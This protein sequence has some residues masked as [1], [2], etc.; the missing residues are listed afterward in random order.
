MNDHKPSNFAGGRPA[1]DYLSCLAKKGNPKKVPPVRRPSGFL[2]QPQASGAAQLAL[3]GHTNR[4]PLRSS[5]IT[6][7]NL[8][9]L[10]ADRG[11]AQG[12]ENLKVL[13]ALCA[14]FCFVASVA[15]ATLAMARAEQRQD[16]S[17]QFLFPERMA[18][19]EFCGYVNS[20]FS[21]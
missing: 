3:T 2:D 11:G 8:R 17:L 20:R 16:L 21:R 10:A 9:L 5:D 14:Q 13:C 7:L 15:C 4:A 1:T 12:N 6:R 18:V 19:V